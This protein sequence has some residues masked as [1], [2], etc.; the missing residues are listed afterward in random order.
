MSSVQHLREFISERLT[1]AA[2]EI[3]S[4]FEKTIVQYEEEIDRQRRLLDVTWKPQ[5]KLDKTD[6]PEQRVHEEEEVLD[7]QQLCNQEKNSSPNQEEFPEIKEEHEELCTRQEGE[8]LELKQ[9]TENSVPVST[10]QKN[11]VS[12]A[13]TNTEQ[14]SSHNSP[15]PEIQN[16]EGNRHIDSTSQ[17]NQSHCNDDDSPMSEIQFDSDTI[18]KS[19]KRDV[20]EQTFKSETEMLQHDRTGGKPSAQQTCKKSMSKTTLTHTRIPKAE[21]LHFSERC[22]KSFSQSHQFI[23]MRTHTGEKLFKCKTCGKGFIRRGNFFRHM[24]AHAGE[25]TYSCKTCGKGFSKQWN[26]LRHMRTHT[27]ERPFTCGTCGKKC[28]QGSHLLTHMR[29]H[30]G[31]KPYICVTCGKGFSCSSALRR[32]LTI[33]TS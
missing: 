10:Y 27:G 9:E 19:A 2:E 31:E 6:L 17:R 4:E 26:L 23:H 24:R 5:I 28:S 21:K 15:S 18:E 25:R 1:A 16:Q 12:E 3:F 7:E 29:V 8:Q 14:L 30:T 20:Y 22:G 33:H 13:E 32:H 11:D